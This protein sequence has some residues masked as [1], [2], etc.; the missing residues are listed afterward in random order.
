[1]A[2]G[3]SA[4]AAAKTGKS[5]KKSGGAGGKK[6]GGASVSASGYID[7][8]TLAQRAVKSLNLTHESFWVRSRVVG[9]MPGWSLHLMPCC[10]AMQPCADPH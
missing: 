2:A 1:M 8:V 4:D 6:G 7:V 3:A 5:K 9:W 10:A